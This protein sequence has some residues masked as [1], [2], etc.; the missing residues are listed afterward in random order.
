VGGAPQ[1]NAREIFAVETV[2]KAAGPA[3][4][5][6]TCENGSLT[7]LTIIFLFMNPV[8]LTKAAKTTILA[9]SK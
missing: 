1:V 2:R 7:V 9:V 4:A 5:R 8:G 3:V 6:L